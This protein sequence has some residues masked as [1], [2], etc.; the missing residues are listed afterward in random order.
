MELLI[1]CLKMLFFIFLSER[2]NLD[3][4]GLMRRFCNKIPRFFKT[5]DYLGNT[6]RED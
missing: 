5:K 1:I 2:I 4:D 6:G 3:V